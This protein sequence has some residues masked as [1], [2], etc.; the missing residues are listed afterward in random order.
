MKKFAELT[1]SYQLN[2]VQQEHYSD[3]VNKT[4]KMIG[5]SY[6]VT[7]R[8]VE[9]WEPSYL[10]SLYQDCISKWRNRGFNG[11]SHMWWTERKKKIG[12]L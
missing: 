12:K 5:R 4:A 7:L 10:D 9:S 1:Q 3:L 6:I 2:E 8:M 11:P